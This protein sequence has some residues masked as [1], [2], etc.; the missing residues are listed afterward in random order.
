MRCLSIYSSKSK[1]IIN[2]VRSTREGNF[3]S[4]VCYFI[5]RIMGL[6]GPW[7]GGSG[8]GGQVVHGLGLGHVVHGQGSGGQ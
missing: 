2:H 6:G 4:P 5:D 8:H 7:C 1:L 3:I